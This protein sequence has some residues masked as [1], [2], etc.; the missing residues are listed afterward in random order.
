MVS[1]AAT[2]PAA[3]LGQEVLLRGLP[4]RV[5]AEGAHRTEAATGRD[6]TPV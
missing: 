1:S 3:A 2:K 5:V 6:A 4:P